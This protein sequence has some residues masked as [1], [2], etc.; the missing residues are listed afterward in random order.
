MELKDLAASRAIE[1]GGRLKVQSALNPAL[2]LCA[3]ISTPA[4]CVA[5]FS[6][7]PPNWLPWLIIIPVVIACLGFIFLLIFD[8]DKLQSE[9]YQI[10]KRSLELIEQKGMGSPV[11]LASSNDI[12]APDA[13]L[14]STEDN[15]Q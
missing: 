9:D 14:G 3:I 1:S 4:L 12:V 15:E 8:R 10:R 2:W 11:S 13:L 5:G 6:E 7:S